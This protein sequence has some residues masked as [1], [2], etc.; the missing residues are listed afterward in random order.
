MSLKE[1]GNFDYVVLL[2]DHMEETRRFYE[3]IMGFALQHDSENW[4]SFK[5]LIGSF[6][7]TTSN[8]VGERQNIQ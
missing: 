3:D 8:D 1:I 6:E 5:A 4:V 7:L 2:C